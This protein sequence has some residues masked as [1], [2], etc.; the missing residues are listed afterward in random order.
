MKSAL[1]WFEI[2][3]TDFDRAV[4]FYNTILAVELR[5]EVSGGVP[6]GV[7]PYERRDD[8]RDN[9][10]GIGG[11]IIY[12]PQVKPSRDGITVYLDVS[13]KMD[14]V[15]SRVTAAGGHVILPKTDMG[16]GHIA[17]I[18]DTEGNRVGLHAY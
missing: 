17:L 13:G 11:S 4:T 3:T 6:N 16:M 14:D 10:R 15:L 18:I 1:N 12:D 5:R 8:G 2:P 9:E 7:F